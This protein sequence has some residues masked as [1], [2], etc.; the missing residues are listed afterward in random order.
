MAV[1]E[2]EQEYRMSLAKTNKKRVAFTK[3]CDVSAKTLADAIRDYIE[4]EE[5]LEAVLHCVDLCQNPKMSCESLGRIL[6][7]LMEYQIQAVDLSCNPHLGDS[8]VATIQ[9]LL[10]AKKSHLAD[11]KLAGC[12]LTVAGL[13]WLVKVASKSRLR[14][15][16]ISYI[17]IRDESE[18][19]E[20]VLELPMIEELALRFCD[21][22]P[23]DVRTIADSLPF[24]GVKSL[25]LAGNTF[26]CQGLV[27]LASKLPE[28]MVEKLDLSKVGIEAKCEGLSQLAKAWA[29]RPF[30]KLYLQ[31]NPMGS[32]EVMNFITALQTLM[33]SE[34][35]DE[36]FMGN[37]NMRCC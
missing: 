5:L 3:L 35:V 11:L 2:T 24:T 23:S 8:M 13:K 22:G 19:I 1:S 30:P 28:S 32:A 20:Q 34:T 37:V 16:D 29:K 26:G 6:E 4:K 18:L 27:H 14:L 12:S 31:N 17:R 15:L 33:P 25:D 9:P 21:L 10:E 36:T 7:L